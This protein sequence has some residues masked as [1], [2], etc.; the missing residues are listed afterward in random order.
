MSTSAITKVLMKRA[1]ETFSVLNHSTIE[2]WI[3]RSGSRP[4]WSDN[5]LRMAE[6]GNFQGGQGGARGVL[7]KHPDV[8]RTITR[9][10]EDLRRAGAALTLVSI[11]GV[12]VATTL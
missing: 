12:V 1:P 9:C 5:A 10:L 11:R 4:R 8:V 2:G 6:K 3:D 7:S